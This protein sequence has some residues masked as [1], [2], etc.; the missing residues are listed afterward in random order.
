M[1]WDVIRHWDAT[2]FLGWLFGVVAMV[3]LFMAVR[4]AEQGVT[5]TAMRYWCATASFIAI[6][7]ALLGSRL[8]V[9]VLV[10][11]YNHL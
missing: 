10:E 11:G 2:R 8:L 4:R 3:S 9:A 1:T 6:G 7:I 5:E